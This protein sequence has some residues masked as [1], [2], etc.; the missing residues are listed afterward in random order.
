MPT[1]RTLL[2][3]GSRLSALLGFF[4]VAAVAGTLIACVLTPGIALAGTAAKQQIGA[5]QDLPSNLEITPLDQ[6]TRMY[7]MDGKKRVLLASFFNQNRESVK[8]DDVPA[9]VKNATIAGEDVRF[10]QHGAV[11]P[12]GIAR[13]LVQNLRG[14]DIQGASTITQQYV[15]NVCVQQAEAITDPD[16]MDAAYKACTATSINRKIREMRLAIGVEKKYSKDEILLGY[17]NIAGFGGRTYGIEAAAHY[18]FDKDAK[19][20]SIGEAATLMSIVNNPDKFRLDRK[21]NLEGAEVRRNHIL[22]VERDHGMISAADYEKYSSEDI[23]TKITPPS[24]GCETAGTAAFFC[25][26]VQNTILTSPEFGKNPTER[27]ANLYTKGWTI[28]TT[29]DLNLQKK[30]Q[31]A[32]DRYVPQKPG[33]A[34]VGAATTSVQVGTGRVLT[35]V[36]NKTFRPNGAKPRTKY[37]AVNYNVNEK[38]GA[39]AGFQPGSTFKAFTM[40][41]WL[42]SGHSMNQSVNGNART[43]PQSDFYSSCGGVGGQPWEFGND[44]DEKGNFTIQEGTARSINGVFASLAEEQ[45]LCKLREIAQ[46]MGVANAAVERYSSGKKKGQIVRNEDGT[47]K[48][49]PLMIVPAMSIGGAS[50]IAPLDNAVGYATI[51]NKGVRCDA[52]GIDSITDMDGKK[53]DI[54]KAD[55]RRVQPEDLMIAAGYDLRNPVTGYNGNGRGTMSADRLGDGRY[56]FGKTGTTDN[57]KDTWAMGST[58]KVTTAVWVGNVTGRANLRFVYSPHGCNSGTAYA[59]MRHCIFQAVQRTM[60]NKY[61]GASSWPS[62]ASQYVSGGKAIQHADARPQSKPKPAAKISSPSDDKPDEDKKPEKKD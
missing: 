12:N 28:N 36:Q 57:A 41:G 8:W 16:K 6:K 29:I 2:S 44:E 10:Y 34:D 49:A 42:K 3:A 14:S 55:C 35:M 60:N 22:A 59:S 13:A 52:I 50:S 58:T 19:D 26:Y 7:A 27:R 62:P 32:V 51:A 15:K 18:Y 38:L 23:K 25:T 4:A 48:I 46:S 30:A 56:L 54:P 53:I 5:F 43:I 1:S 45:D 9:T 61:G 21:E 31:K 33:A 37:S 17:L 40:I 20:L 47:A 39:G 11:D 24:T